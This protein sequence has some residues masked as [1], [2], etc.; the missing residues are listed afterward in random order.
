MLS[1]CSETES[2][3]LTS[4]VADLAA[5]VPEFPPD[6][7]VFH[8]AELSPDFKRWECTFPTAEAGPNAACQETEWG[9]SGIYRQVIRDL[10]ARGPLA[11][12]LCGGPAHFDAIRVCSLAWIDGP[13]TPW[14]EAGPRGC[15]L[16][17]EPVLICGVA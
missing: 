6:A 15:V 3:V 14:G 17:T 4:P 2:A 8:P 11:Q 12:E 10:V 16:V 7:W 9:N 1:A 5:S 13:E